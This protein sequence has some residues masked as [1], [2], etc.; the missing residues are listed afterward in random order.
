MFLEP[1]VVV[2]TFYSVTAVWFWGS[3]VGF[4]VHEVVDF[5]LN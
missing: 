3:S 4:E 1:E 5:V 2:S